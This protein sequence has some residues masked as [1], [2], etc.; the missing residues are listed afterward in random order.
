MHLTWPL[1]DLADRS[2]PPPPPCL[3]LSLPFLLSC[4]L[5]TLASPC[6]STYWSA[7]PVFS[8]PL[9]PG[10]SLFRHRLLWNGLKSLC[11]LLCQ[12]SISKAVAHKSWFFGLLTW[13]PQLYHFSASGQCCLDR[14][15]DALSL[16]QAPHLENGDN[17]RLYLWG[18]CERKIIL[19]KCW[20]W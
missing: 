18:Y 2:L 1:W 19:A 12:T 15:K 13:A 17:K 9:Q 11:Q 8:G 4:P 14:P 16:S 7:F 5:V 6:F 20:E 10:R 3:M